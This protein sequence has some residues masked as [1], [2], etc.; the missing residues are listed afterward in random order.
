[1]SL[2]FSLYENRE[3]PFMSRITRGLL[4]S[5]AVLFT[6]AVG[7]CGEEAES[8]G[9]AE[10]GGT[11]SEVLTQARQAAEDASAE[12][13]AWPGPTEAP[14]MVEGKFVVVIPCAEAAEGCRRETDGFVEAAKVVGW[15]TQKIDGQGNNDVISSGI[16]K[17]ITLG[18]DG[19]FLSAVDEALVK[20]A[21]AKARDAGLVVINSAAPEQAPT[22]DGFNH[23]VALPAREEGVVMGSYIISETEGRPRS[24]CSTTVSSRARSPVARAPARCWRTARDA[25][26]SPR[27]ST[28]SPSSAPPS[29]R[30]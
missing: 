25:A 6:V 1:M 27:R 11:G 17:A 20:R 13:T 19:V 16:E 9:A 4:G 22:D 24:R 3:G 2:R 30:G 15:K 28:P 26:S 14:P 12:R 10:A 8:G 5:L 21:V 29:P 18:A 7:A 23:V